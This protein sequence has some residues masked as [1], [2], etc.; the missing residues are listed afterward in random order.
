MEVAD[1]QE[2]I[3]RYFDELDGSGFAYAY[4][5]PGINRVLQAAGRVIR[6]ASDRGLIVLIDRRYA[7][8][9]YNDLLP[10]GWRPLRVGRDEALA[11]ALTGFWT[12][13]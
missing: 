12:G 8:A 2:L 11:P 1:E 3:R 9:A 7:T 6:S 10:A 5:Y 13:E 4:R